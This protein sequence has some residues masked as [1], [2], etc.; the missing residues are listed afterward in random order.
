MFGLFGLFTFR[1]LTL[2][3]EKETETLLCMIIIIKKSTVKLD[4]N[5]DVEVG[6]KQND[7]EVGNFF[8][9]QDL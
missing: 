3:F 1:T 2:S 5:N 8:R 6:L 4:S 9:Y 7:V